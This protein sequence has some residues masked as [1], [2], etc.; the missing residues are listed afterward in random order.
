MP[1]IDPAHLAAVLAHLNYA[2]RGHGSSRVVDHIVMPDGDVWLAVE[3]TIDLCDAH[4]TGTPLDTPYVQGVLARW[5][6]T[7]LGTDGVI[8]TPEWRQIRRFDCPA[9]ILARLSPIELFIERTDYGR[10]SR[11]WA[12]E[13]RERCWAGV[14]AAAA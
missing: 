7:W 8:V 9:R 1:T 12:K 14:E 6:R 5:G 3:R 10:G 2:D 11:E 13:W 4:R